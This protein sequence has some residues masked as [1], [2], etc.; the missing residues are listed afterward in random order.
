MRNTMRLNK[1]LCITVALIV[2]TG[3][4]S[5]QR[6]S[7]G[8]FKNLSQN[9]QK[10]LPKK[11]HREIT[12]EEK[13]ELFKILPLA[14]MAAQRGQ[15]SL[16]ISNYLT[17]AELSQNEKLAAKAIYYAEK[18]DDYLSSL[19]A[20][21]LWNNIEP[22]SLIAN[23]MLV[24]GYMRS[25]RSDKIQQTFESILC[26]SQTKPKD[27]LL[28]NLEMIKQD[29]PDQFSTEDLVAFSE[30]HPKNVEILLALA[31]IEQLD[32]HTQKAQ[33]Y[34]DKA[35]KL[36]QKD[37]TALEIKGLMLTGNGS[38]LEAEQFFYEAS[39]KNPKA[40]KLKLHLA[41]LYYQKRDFDGAIQLASKLLDDKQLQNESKFIIASAHFAQQK[42][43]ESEQLFLELLQANY[44]KDT[45]N[46]FLAQIHLRQQ[47]QDLALQFF[48]SITSGNY[49]LR[50][51]IEAALLLSKNGEYSQARSRL[52]N[53]THANFSEQIQLAQID[54]KIVML[55]N[56]LESERST[57]LKQ[58]QDN[59][60][61]IFYFGRA[62]IA[63]DKP[64]DKLDITNKALQHVEAPEMQKN[65]II[66]ASEILNRQKQTQT[67]LL[68]LNDYLNKNPRELD[69]LYNQSM[70]KAQLGDL[71]GMESDLRKILVQDKNHTDALNALGYSLAD[72]NTDLDNAYKMI[73][74]AFE[75]SPNSSAISDSLGWVLFRQGKINEALIHLKNAWLISPSA[76]IGAHLGEVYWMNKEPQQAQD[77]WLEA[78]SIDPNNL[79]LKETMQRLIPSTEQ[80][81]HQ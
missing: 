47:N 14:D 53:M 44:R 58:Y 16:A 29:F 11:A 42:Y 34:V 81:S 8:A 40:N 32:E 3:C 17:A 9:C 59:P 67:A 1:Q 72:K 75:Q 20:A 22:T 64:Q 51:R 19:E 48:D 28:I 63:A 27:T 78:Q 56:K 24:I 10:I 12:E 55:A 74:Q 6:S 23:R 7:N 21:K 41:Q 33:I 62:L 15:F 77:I 13:A 50:A 2:L 26:I 37:E 68:I 30:K 18:T 79:T 46:F 76:E 45:L 49:L 73:M 36:A 66:A 43:P 4:A 5:G 65:I 71:N 25:H 69:I 39:K 60:E 61:N 57:I 38:L 70:L 35:L 52:Q 31:K 54:M 80:I